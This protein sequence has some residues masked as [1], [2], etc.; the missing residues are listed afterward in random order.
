MSVKKIRDA[1]R[2]AMLMSLMSVSAMG[3]AADVTATLMTAQQREPWDGKVDIAVTFTGASND[4]AN[5][6][7]TFVATNSTTKAA[8][9]VTHLT[10]IEGAVGSGT[11]W[12]RRFIWDAIADLGK[13]KI[14]DIALAVATKIAET[15]TLGGV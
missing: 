4:V 12:Q 14:D 3:V 9:N 5:A 13:V 15:D 6:A 2:S 8:L 7:C 1:A 10:V 11:T